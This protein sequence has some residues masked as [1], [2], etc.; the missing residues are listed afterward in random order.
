M[1][2]QNLAAH[3]TRVMSSTAR[4]LLG[5]G[6]ETASGGRSRNLGNFKALSLD[7]KQIDREFIEFIEELQTFA[8]G[9]LSCM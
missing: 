2:C 8:L 9:Y 1:P 7:C 5:C 6:P 3:K 4:E